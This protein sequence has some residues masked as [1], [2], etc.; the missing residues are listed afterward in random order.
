MAFSG[1]SYLF[2]VE[3]FYKKFIKFLHVSAEYEAL[4]PDASPDTRR[5]SAIQ[6]DIA[7]AELL[8]AEVVDWESLFQRREMTRR[9]SVPALRGRRGSL[10]VLQVQHSK[11]FG[12]D[13][14]KK[15]KDFIRCV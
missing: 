9:Q 15:S 12:H 6:L 2:C 7:R 11:S 10:F 3:P 4:P 13:I 1:F 5:S 8:E 14:T